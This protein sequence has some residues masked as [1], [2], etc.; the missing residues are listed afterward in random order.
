MSRDYPDPDMQNLLNAARR[1]SNS[2]QSSSPK[3]FSRPGVRPE[4]EHRGSL[5]SS[6]PSSRKHHTLAQLS[7]HAWAYTGFVGGE[8]LTRFQGAFQVEAWHQQTPFPCLHPWKCA[9]VNTKQ[10]FK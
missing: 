6:R 8:G 5:G 2:T 3:P 1:Y 9:R 10:N 7:E 4:Q